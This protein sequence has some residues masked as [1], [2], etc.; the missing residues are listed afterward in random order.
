MKKALIT[1]LLLFSHMAASDEAPDIEQLTAEARELISA[2]AG[3]LQPALRNA[4]QAGGP[5]EAINVCSELAP[6]IASD[7][8]SESGWQ[9]G[10][11]SLKARNH[12]LA[13]PDNWEQVQLK[14]FA[15]RRDEGEKPPAINYG[16]VVGENFRYMQAQGV[17]PVCL[18]C[19]GQNIDKAT[20]KALDQYYPHDTATGYSLGEIRGA[21]SLS[22][23]IEL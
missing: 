1:L 14:V 16:E 3:Q 18:A 11:V 19:H 4:M 7:L 12:S 5:V 22:R 13:I 10:R 21:F 20:Q 17:E 9:V 6:Q 8:A 15:K 2:F 23:P